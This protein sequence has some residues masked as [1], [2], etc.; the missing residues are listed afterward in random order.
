MAYT[1]YSKQ[2]CVFCKR[3]KD[4]L[5]LLG[6]DFTEIDITEGDNRTQ[7]NERLGY[8]ARTVPQIWHG[9]TY[10]GGFTELSTY[11]K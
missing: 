6:E 7:L 2:S 3:A 10:V 5:D 11:V 9:D 4:L 1:V 8:E